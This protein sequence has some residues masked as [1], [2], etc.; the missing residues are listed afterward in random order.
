[1]PADRAGAVAGIILAAGT[2]T[3]MGRN[4]LL[5]ALDGETFLRRAVR[6][7]TE[8]GLDPVIVVLGHEAD[9]A[10]RELAQLECRTVVNTEYAR[11]INS[12]LHTGLAALPAEPRAVV[13]MLADMPFVTAEMIATLVTRYRE[14][15]APLVVSDYDG[16]HAPPQLYDRSLFPEL[17]AME[18]EGCGKQVVRR[19]RSEA[20]VVSWPADALT[21]VD[22]P[23]DFERV[24]ARLAVG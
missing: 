1:M 24:K 15:T 12:S 8:A 19:H 13:V 3:R 22:V 18:G 10:R 11:G 7:A 21:D 14:G 23:E 4:K 20:T 5:F 9:Q 16:V 17:L 2:S 6:G